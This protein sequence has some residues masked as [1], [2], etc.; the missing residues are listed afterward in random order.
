MKA[1]LLKSGFISL[2]LVYAHSIIIAMSGKGQQRCF[3]VRSEFSKPFVNFSYV[4]FSEVHGGNDIEFTLT[5]YETGKVISKTEPHEPSNQRIFRFENDGLTIYK[6]C[7]VAPNDYPKKIKIYIEHSTREDIID[8][9]NLSPSKR[10]LNE[11]NEEERSLE[12]SIFIDYL[13]IKNVEEELDKSNLL[14]KSAAVI[15]IVFFGIAAVFQFY[16]VIGLMHRL[17]VNFS[18]IV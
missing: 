9:D 8:K 11:L 6:G 4:V 5:N 12:S 3:L 18:D 14:L 7:F 2:F 17:N 1:L 16:T 13:T 15:K 10:M